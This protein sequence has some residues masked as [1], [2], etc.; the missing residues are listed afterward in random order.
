MRKCFGEAEYSWMRNWSGGGREKV[1]ILIAD[2]KWC[3][4][5]I[6]TMKMRD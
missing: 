4:Y 2:M 3:Y 1:G 5:A 6:L